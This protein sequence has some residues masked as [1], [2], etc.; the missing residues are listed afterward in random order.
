[1]KTPFLGTA[2]YP[3]DWDISDIP[4]DIAKMKEAGIKV[5]RIA[6]FAWRRMEPAPGQYEFGW[7]HHV[8]DSLKEAGIKV[9][10][11][12]PTATPPIWLIREHPDVTIMGSDGVHINHGGRR[13]C[14]SN[15]PAYIKAS[16]GIVRALAEE[17]GHDENVIGWQIDNE[18][19]ASGEGCCCPHC[20][21]AFHRQLEE[22][23][24]TIEELNRQWNLNLFSQ[25]YDSFEEIPAAVR[26]WHN[27][28]LVYEW[29]VFQQESQIRFVHRQAD[30]LRQAV[31]A[32]IS[33]DMMPVNGLDYEKMNEK[34]DLVMFNHYNTEENLGD[35]LFW[36]D[37]L[38]TI[39]KAPFW[40]TETQTSWNGSTAIGQT[41][42]P[43]GFCRI[44]S[45]LPVALGGEANMYWLWRQHWAGHELVHGALLYPSGRPFHTFGEVQE[46]AAQFEKASDFISGT[47]VDTRVA[48][49]F[50][51]RNW[52]LLEAQPVFGEF[53]YAERL[54]HDFHRPLTRLGLRPDVIGAR[55]DLDGY[56]ILFSPYMLT[57]EDG[58][59]PQRI[60]KWVR[61]GGIWIVGPMTDIRNAIGAHYRDCETGMIE[62]MTGCQLT[63]SMPDS[64]GYVSSV[65]DDGSSFRG[66]KWYELY[67]PGADA[68]PL[69][70]VT[71]GHSAIVGKAVALQVKV[72]AGKIIL[73][74]S[75]PSEED[76]EKIVRLA[77]AGTDIEIPETTGDM[78]VVPRKGNG[79]SGMI[80]AEYGNAKASCTLKSPMT[81]ILTGRTCQGK[82]ELA[83]YELL[84][85]EEQGR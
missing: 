24:G 68:Q 54:I 21:D 59:L 12:T 79:R 78:A 63:Y 8:V 58:D 57:L 18:I 53:R 2:Y 9:V 19:Y 25:A 22:K 23:Y 28:H 77:A 74:G 73:L 36:F 81:D 5:A 1:M 44:N 61:D 45:W 43:E 48:I 38:R 67:T 64:L 15:H 33:T 55:K 71:G 70:T 3:E 62:R 80:F 32:P 85:L 52:N 30:I 66:D 37:Y 41:M 26:A 20:M 56:K 65:W 69:V 75:I 17:F 50:T 51:S 46:T 42:K 84:V 10:M 40:N 39:K 29:K 76:L 35:S 31:D 34:L 7:L 47:S 11:G 83:P 13:H 49:H 6:E 14:C 82:V 60:E 16:E 27:P 72:G 4:Q